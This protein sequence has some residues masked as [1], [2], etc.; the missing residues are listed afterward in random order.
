MSSQL[1]ILKITYPV[2]ALLNLLQVAKEDKLLGTQHNQ[3]LQ[4]IT[5]SLKAEILN[6]MLTLVWYI[7]L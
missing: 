2:A 5:T 1:S 4:I 7:C 6:C 3:T